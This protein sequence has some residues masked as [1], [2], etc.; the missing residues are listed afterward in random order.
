V[1]GFILT[2]VRLPGPG[3]TALGGWG[4]PAIP[5]G[6]DHHRAF[7][8]RFGHDVLIAA[9]TEDLPCQENRV[10]LDPEVT[11]SSGVPAARVT[12]TAHPQDRDLITFGMARAREVFEAAGAT[13]I[14][15]F[16]TYDLPLGYHLLGSARMGMDPRNSVINK[17]HQTWEIPN[18]FLCDGSSFVTG[19]CTHPTSTIG[20][21]ATRLADRLVS[22]GP[23]MFDESRA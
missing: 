21:L 6:P 16:G 9:V 11:D 5:W 23:K 15:E 22:E 1:N 8:G 17:W 7:A 19:G 12:W 13:E 14:Y 2:P 10:T 3:V 20:A 4:M 18:L